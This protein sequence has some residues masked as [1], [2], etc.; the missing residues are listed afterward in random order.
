MFS[1]AQLRDLTSKVSPAD[2]S[3]AAV[4]AAAAQGCGAHACDSGRSAEPESVAF[5]LSHVVPSMPARMPA[6]E[7]TLSRK[8]ARAAARAELATNTVVCL[9]KYNP[10]RAPYSPGT[11]GAKVTYHCPVWPG[12]PGTVRPAYVTIPDEFIGVDPTGRDLYR[13]RPGFQVRFWLEIADTTATALNRQLVYPDDYSCHL[14]FR[15]ILEA[16]LAGLFRPSGGGRPWGG[17]V[18]ASAPPGFPCP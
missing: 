6:Q 8:T 3:G 13:C 17:R 18:Q 10:C 16:V 11:W 5:Q 9:A 14:G 12:F 4:A 1:R 7:S 2:R 15:T